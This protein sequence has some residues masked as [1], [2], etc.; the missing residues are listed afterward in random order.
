MTNTTVHRAMV[1]GL[2]LVMGIV[3]ALSVRDDTLTTD[4]GLYIPTGYMYLNY[5]SFLSYFNEAVG[6]GREGSWYLVD[7]DCDWG[8]DAKRLATWA[9][10][11]DIPK[12]KVA[13]RLLF[14]PSGSGVRVESW[15]Y[16]R[17][18]AHYLGERYAR[19]EPGVEE[20]GWIAVPARLLRWGQA[21]PAARAGWSSDSYA[22][23][24]ARQPIT[25][26]GNSISVYEIW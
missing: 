7:T 24:A 21:R 16:S 11:H 2:L 8:Q 25:V 4:E 1:V 17:S 26:I 20:K 6:G 15:V 19:L 13:H 23:L 5:P 3:M 22:W 18:Y 14:Q 9:A 10:E 12:I